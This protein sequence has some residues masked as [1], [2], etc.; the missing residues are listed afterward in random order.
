M[1]SDHQ[2]IHHDDHA[3]VITVTNVTAL[4]HLATPAAFAGTP[5]DCFWHPH[6]PL[7]CFWHRGTWIWSTPRGQPVRLVEGGSAA[8]DSSG[9]HFVVTTPRGIEDWPS[10][11]TVSTLLPH[12]DHPIDTIHMHPVTS[13][14]T[15]T[16][17]TQG[18]MTITLDSMTTVRFE[19]PPQPMR[20]RGAWRPNGTT[21]AAVGTTNRHGNQSTPQDCRLILWSAA[22]ALSSVSAS[23]PM[24]GY[25]PYWHPYD[26]QGVLVADSALIWW[27]DQEITAIV[28]RTPFNAWDAVAGWESSGQYLAVMDTQQI[29][30]VRADGAL[31]GQVDI[32]PDVGFESLA[33]HPREPLLA[34]GAWDSLIRLWSA[35][36]TLLHVVNADPRPLAWER[37]HRTSIGTPMA[38]RWS[39]DGAFLA[40]ALRDGS[41]MVYSIPAHPT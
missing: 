2:S 41:I 11:A 16:S 39:A 10:S 13:M 26:N 6:K 24:T 40:A 34:T 23:L 5:R 25:A 1:Y 32:D 31:H 18:I 7:L 8:W 3:V 21:F 33:W 20:W 15:L 38:L 27:K 30:V 37:T 35:D 9:V 36:G 22:G 12:G 4:Q 29:R 14:L 17:Q 19:D 28:P